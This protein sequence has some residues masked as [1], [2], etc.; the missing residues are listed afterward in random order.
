MNINKIIN[1]LKEV[2]VDT[3]SLE[4]KLKKGIKEF[5]GT[6]LGGTK[7]KIKDGIESFEDSEYEDKAVKFLNDAVNIPMV[8]EK[9]EGKYIKRIVKGCVD[10]GK[11]YALEGIDFVFDKAEEKANEEIDGLFEKRKG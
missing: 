4:S 3:E 11:P 8:S 1:G 7:E 5:V 2:G 6:L 9:T 10:T